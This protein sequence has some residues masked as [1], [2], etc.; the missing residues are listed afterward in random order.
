VS[1]VTFNGRR[2]A[3]RG[4]TVYYVTERCVLRLTGHG[5][6]LV[7]VAPGLDVERDVLAHMDFRPIVAADLRTMDAAICRNGLMGLKDRP[8]VSMDERVRFDVAS[9]SVYVNFEGLRLLTVE[10]VHELAQ[11]LDKRFAALGRQVHVVV[12]YDNFF[13]STDAAEEFFAMVRRNEERFFLSST[14][15]STNAFFRRQLGR[16]FTEHDLYANFSEAAVSA[17]RRGTT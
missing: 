11:E 3:E 17:E 4:Q 12:N 9:N 15:Y 14:R 7:E 16:K 6:E 10:D 13:L 1:Q 5:L 8:P 2:A